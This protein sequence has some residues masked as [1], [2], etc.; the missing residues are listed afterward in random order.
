MTQ[1]IIEGFWDENKETKKIINIMSLNKVNKIKNKIK[2]INKGEHIN[3]IIYTILVI[4]YLKSK[5]KNQLKEY[6]LVINKAIK[7][8]KKNNIDYDD[9]AS[10]I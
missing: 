7:F 10:H 6:R 3:K 5:C 4:Y 2:E 9:I 1:D 8:L